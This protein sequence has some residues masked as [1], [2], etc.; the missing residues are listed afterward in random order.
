MALFS[1]L[2]INTITDHNSTVFGIANMVPPERYFPAACYVNYS[3]LFIGNTINNV[4][5]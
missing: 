2:D 4:I 1:Q 5:P 3:S